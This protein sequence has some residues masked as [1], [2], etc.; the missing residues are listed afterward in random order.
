MAT[1][2]VAKSAKLTD[3]LFVALAFRNALEYRNAVNSA[4]DMLHRLEI[5]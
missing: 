5:W 1:D 4:D 3:R 2:F